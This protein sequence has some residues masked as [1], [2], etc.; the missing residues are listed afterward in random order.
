MEAPSMV[1]MYF[2]ARST[3]SVQN[4]RKQAFS[5]VFTWDLDDYEVPINRHL[6]AL[7]FCLG[8]TTHTW[9]H[10]RTRGL[11]FRLF[12][13]F[14]SLNDDLDGVEILL[15]LR[16]KVQYFHDVLVALLGQTFVSHDQFLDLVG[17]AKHR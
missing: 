17:Q 7:L 11:L 15:L 10:H 12:H 16:A 2:A 8:W 1:L 5:Q 6:N 14:S 4:V 13:K 9:F 3:I